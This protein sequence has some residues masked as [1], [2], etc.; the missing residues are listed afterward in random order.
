MSNKII[1]YL[2][3][4]MMFFNPGLISAAADTPLSDSGDDPAVG[5]IARGK[6]REAITI[7]LATIKKNSE[8]DDNGIIKRASFNNYVNTVRRVRYLSTVDD[9][10]L[11]FRLAERLDLPESELKSMLAPYMQDFNKPESFQEFVV[12]LNYRLTFRQLDNIEG[13][14][15][16]FKRYLHTNFGNEKTIKKQYGY[17]Y[18]YPYLMGRFLFLKGEYDK[19]AQYLRL[20]LMFRPDYNGVAYCDI[21]NNYQKMKRGDEAKKLIRS[22][23]ASQRETAEFAFFYSLYHE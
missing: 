3:I 4:S 15:N 20:A 14:L 6:Y 8:F 10:S 21:I 13:L 16:R 1:G 18:Y 23:L 11:I 7:L 12:T 9:I 2:L 17:L 19:S 22:V 5:C